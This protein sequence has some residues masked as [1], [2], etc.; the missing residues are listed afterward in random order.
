MEKK[1]P[2]VAGCITEAL[3]LL[4]KT[5][6][7]DDISITEIIEKAGVSRVSFYRNFLSKEDVLERHLTRIT[8][9]FIAASGISF[10]ENTLESFF[11]ILFLHMLKHKAFTK[12]L[13]ASNCLYLV[14]RQFRRIFAMRN[15]DYDDFKKEF[16]IGG[17]FSVYQRWLV[18]GCRESP[19]EMAARLSDLLEK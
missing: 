12:N 18:K 4:I 8:D 7:L 9:E 15:S 17:I 13:A 19:K 6:S 1:N 3:L 5:K 10:R 14:E 2:F 11:E 16:Y